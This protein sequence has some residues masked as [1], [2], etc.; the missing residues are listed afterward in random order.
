MKICTVC[1]IMKD[2][3]DFYSYFRKKEGKTYTQ[4]RCKE[5]HI[6]LTKSRNVEE[7]GSLLDPELDRKRRMLVRK[8]NLLGGMVTEVDIYRLIDIYEELPW[9]KTIDSLKIDQQILIMWD[10]I[11]KDPLMIKKKCSMCNEWKESFKNFKIKKSENLFRSYCNECESE[12]QKIK[13]EKYKNNH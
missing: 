6:T 8:F 11:Q 13:R 3:S 2:D 1:G 7:S 4:T 9:R 5:C 12:L 10:A